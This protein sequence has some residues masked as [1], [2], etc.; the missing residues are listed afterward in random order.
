VLVASGSVE[1]RSA[2]FSRDGQGF[3]F[4]RH[5]CSG[6]LAY[7]AASLVRT[8]AKLLSVRVRGSIPPLLHTRSWSVR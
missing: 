6:P 7:P 4:C 2:F 5:V 3:S 1:W 8:D